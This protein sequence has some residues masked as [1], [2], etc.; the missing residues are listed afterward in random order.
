MS[1][2]IGMHKE[3]SLIRSHG[4]GLVQHGNISCKDDLHSSLVQL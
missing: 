4:F 1:V 2:E 3:R